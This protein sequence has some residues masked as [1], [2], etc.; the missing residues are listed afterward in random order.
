M[1][2]KGYVAVG[3]TAVAARVTR[4]TPLLHDEAYLKPMDIEYLKGLVSKAVLWLRRT[5]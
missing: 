2:Q 1:S 4:I 5:Q 3:A